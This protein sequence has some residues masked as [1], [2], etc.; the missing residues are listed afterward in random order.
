M[1][2]C[3]NAAGSSARSIFA[4]AFRGSAPASRVKS[5]IRSMAEA[6]ERRPRMATGGGSEPTIR[7]DAPLPAPSRAAPEPAR[8]LVLLGIEPG[9]MPGRHALEMRS[10]R[11]RVADALRD[12]QLPRL[13]QL[14]EVLERRVQ[15]D[16]VVDLDQSVLGQPRESCGAW[17]S[18]RR[19]MG[20]R[21]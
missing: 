15:A 8:S 16:V 6:M 14:A 9:R 2:R 20:R 10:A 21:C 18:P 19:R 13:Q 5:S 7:V 4:R 1:L 12:D 11:V 3:T 17:H